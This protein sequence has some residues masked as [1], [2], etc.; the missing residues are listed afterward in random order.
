MANDFQA[1]SEIPG[2]RVAFVAERL[3]R[4]LP[5]G[6]RALEALARH[7]PDA[8]EIE[9]RAMQDGDDMFP[10]VRPNKGKTVRERIDLVLQGL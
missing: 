5:P 7:V 8:A 3:R 4:T 9:R 2:K 1:A 10:D 6:R